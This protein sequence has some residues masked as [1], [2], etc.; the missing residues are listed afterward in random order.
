MVAAPMCA[1]LHIMHL[2][3]G[4]DNKGLHNRFASNIS[5]ILRRGVPHCYSGKNAID[6]T[7]M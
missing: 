7:A 3:V 2:H 4:F 5:I 1:L 6:D